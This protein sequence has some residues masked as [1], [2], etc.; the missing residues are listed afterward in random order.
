[1]GE[2]GILDEKIKS[3]VSDYLVRNEIRSIWIKVLLQM[4]NI[5]SPKAY[6]YIVSG[7]KA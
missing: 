3:V 7:A 4:F 6:F 2:K 1:M 5:S